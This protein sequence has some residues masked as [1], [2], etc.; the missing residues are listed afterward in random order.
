MWLIAKAWYYRYFR[1]M[2]DAQAPSFPA[3]DHDH[4]ACLNRAVQRAKRRCEEVDIKWTKLREKVFRQIATSHTAVRAY[5]LGASLTK[6]GNPIA[7]ISIYRILEVLKEAG[8]VHRLESRNAF[9][10]C[11]TAHENARQTITF[12]CRDCDRV[13][14]IG[15]PGA[16]GAIGE[17]TE[18]AGFT[19][20]TVLIEVGGLCGECREGRGDGALT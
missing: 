11:M 8:L 18:A 20:G 6:E 9:F 13:T 15:A 3:R 10:A 5:D 2:N 19:L 16:Y 12:I 4:S 1:D 7:P 14:E 17:A